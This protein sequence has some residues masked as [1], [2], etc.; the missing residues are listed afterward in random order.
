MEI[1]RARPEV[2]LDKGGVLDPVLVK[3]GQQAVEQPHIGATAH[4]EMEIRH[5]RGSRSPRINHHQLQFR[6]AFLFLDDALEQDRMA[7]SGIGAHQHN[8]FSLLQVI[9]GDRNDVL[10]EGPLVSSHR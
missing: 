8:E 2:C 9:V 5:F 7:P 4:R 6:P 1:V 3:E 10:A